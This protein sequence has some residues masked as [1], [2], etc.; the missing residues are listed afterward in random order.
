M[1]RKCYECAGE[2]LRITSETGRAGKARGKQS[3]FTVWKTLWPE[4]KEIFGMP[5]A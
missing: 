3:F 2:I 1:K 4:R 5:V